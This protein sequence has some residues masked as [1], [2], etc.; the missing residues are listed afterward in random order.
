MHIFVR[1][2]RE[3]FFERKIVFFG[4]FDDDRAFLNGNVNRRTVFDIRFQSKAFRNPQSQTVSPFL[5]L[6]LHKTP[7]KV[8]TLKIL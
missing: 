3:H 1:D 6:N 8:S 5:H 2:L 4:W 7:S